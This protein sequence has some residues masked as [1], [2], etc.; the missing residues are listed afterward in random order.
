[1]S[2]WEHR[3]HKWPE[4]CSYLCGILCGKDTR[5]LSLKNDW[6]HLLKTSGCSRC[7]RVWR[8]QAAWWS[9]PPFGSSW[10]CPLLGHQHIPVQFLSEAS[11]RRN[12]NIPSE[13]SVFWLFSSGE[14]GCQTDFQE[15][16][17]LHSLPAFYGLHPCLLIQSRIDIFSQSLLP[18]DSTRDVT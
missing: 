8:S 3:A 5:R 6:V 14:R 9:I 10:V 12:R 4:I 18:P 7:E 2:W 16:R 13:Q 17:R 1:M 15:V 11:R